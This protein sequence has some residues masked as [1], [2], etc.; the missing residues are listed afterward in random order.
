MH[1]DNALSAI[2]HCSTTL[3][4]CIRTTLCLQLST[5]AQ[6]SSHASGQRSV[7]NCPLQHNSHRMHQDNALSAIVHCSTT[8]IACIRTTLCLQLST[9]AQL[10]SHVSILPSSPHAHSS[11]KR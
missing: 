11:D 2:V 4:A 6:L 9:A 8:L 5:A 7:C 10:S 3:I 1:Q